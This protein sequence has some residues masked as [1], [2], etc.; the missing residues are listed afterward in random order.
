MQ[1]CEVCEVNDAEENDFL[2][3]DCIY[4]MLL[5]YEEEQDKRQFEHDLW[6]MWLSENED[7][8]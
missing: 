5:K 4:N 7:L 8:G 2:C 3:T 6:H 1:M